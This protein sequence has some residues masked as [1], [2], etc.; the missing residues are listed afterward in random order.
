MGI[1]TL[2][3][4]ARVSTADQSLEMQVEALKAAGCDQVFTDVASGAKA[5][6]PG[7]DKALE[8]LREGDTLMVWKIDRL[9]RSLAHLV[10]TVEELRE[11]GVGFRSLTDAGIDTTTRS[12]RLLFNL[13]ATLAEFERDLIRER[14]KAG[15]ANAVARGR[16][17]G[18]R[19]VV[20]PEKLA[21]AQKLMQSAA[22][23][24]KGLTVREAAAAI[25]VGK[26]ALYDALKEAGDTTQDGDE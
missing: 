7:L 22:E 17:G 13:F 9:G 25:K 6:R 3:G 19:P 18:R 11:R 16:N 5:E 23:G 12:G 8:Y 20:T 1:R 14:T 21:R 4:Y 2:I 10:Q 24:G 15:L 26:T